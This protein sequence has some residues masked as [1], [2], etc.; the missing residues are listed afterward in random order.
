MPGKY[1]SESQRSVI[2]ALKN[3]G[4]SNR[5]ISLRIPCDRRTV[6][7]IVHNS[8]NGKVSVPAHKSGRKRISNLRDDATL[9]RSV[10]KD[11][12]S[13]SGEL[14]IIMADHG[15]TM[16]KRTINRR[17]FDMNLKARKPKKK[18]LLTKAMKVAPLKWAKDHRNWTIENWKNVIWSDESKFNLHASDGRRLVR[19]RPGEEY[20]PDCLDR[21]VKF[22]AFV[23]LWACFSWYGIGRVHVCEG[24][25]NQVQY[26]NIL[27]TR[28]LPTIRDFQEKNQLDPAH[29]IFQ[30]DSAPVHRAR[31]VKEYLQ[32]HN[33]TS[34]PWP[35]NSPDLNPIEELWKIMSERAMKLKPT[36]KTDLIAKLLRVW[37]QQLRDLPLIKDLVESMPRRCLAVIKARGGTTKY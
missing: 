20:H 16:S 6:D 28:L 21:T 31:R 35:G 29:V 12:R 24:M 25:V 9:R 37:N 22:P 11:R 32:Q 14:Q 7:R 4:L 27:E 2:C 10:L 13:I 18:P 19:R 1:L 34:L 3:E 33:I 30:D 5:Q 15:V 26:L 36:S 23:M 8:M 17:L